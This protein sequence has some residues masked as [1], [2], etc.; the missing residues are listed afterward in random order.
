[1]C[2]GEKRVVTAPPLFGFGRTDVGKNVPKGTTVRFYVEVGLGL[3]LFMRIFHYIPHRAVLL[4]WFSYPLPQFF[5]PFLHTP[6]SAA[7]GIE[8]HECGGNDNG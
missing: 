1:M 5:F 7:D 2:V 8:R 6:R 3:H 4:I